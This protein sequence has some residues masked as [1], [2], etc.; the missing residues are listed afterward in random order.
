MLNKMDNL[1]AKVEGMSE[2]ID[3]RFEVLDKRCSDLESRSEH[4]SL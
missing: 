3:T 4:D 1:N 2:S